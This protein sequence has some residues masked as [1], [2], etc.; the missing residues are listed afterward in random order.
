MPRTVTVHH[1]KVYDGRTD[2]HITPVRKST[3]ERIKRIAGATIIPDTAE[4][5]DT[6]DLD[7]DGR[8]DPRKGMGERQ[9][10]RS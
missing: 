10:Q 1:F 6:A 5:V 8:Y 7:E 2:E 3:V 9:R 4:E